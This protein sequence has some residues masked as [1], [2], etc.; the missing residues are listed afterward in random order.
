MVRYCSGEEQV[1]ICT[2]LCSK[3]F[4]PPPRRAAQGFQG[5]PRHQA[6]QHGTASSGGSL[7]LLFDHHQVFS[8][9]SR[10]AGQWCL[11]A[12]PGAGQQVAGG[13]PH[14]GSGITGAA[15][16]KVQLT[17]SLHSSWGL[18]LLQRWGEEPGGARPAPPHPAGGHS[19]PYPLQQTLLRERFP[20]AAACPWAEQEAQ[21]QSCLLLS[22]AAPPH[23]RF[24]QLQRTVGFKAPLRFCPHSVRQSCL[25]EASKSHTVKNLL[26][27]PNLTWLCS[28]SSVR[29]PENA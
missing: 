11:T 29:G 3:V 7:R 6:Y 5:L 4:F 24:A 26:F 8:A 10:T 20:G 28:S 2:G 16:D 9:G 1:G 19:H 21:E 23:P 25:S 13:S 27:R 22:P 12:Q 14:L 18:M 15:G 17:A